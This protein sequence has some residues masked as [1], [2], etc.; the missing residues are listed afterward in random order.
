MGIVDLAGARRSAAPFL[1]LGRN[2]IAVFVL[3]TLGAI[4]LLAV[5][6]EG[7]DGKRR[8]LW[9]AIYRGAFE[10]LA[11]PR[12]SSLLFALAYLAVWTAFAGVLYR[13]RIFIKI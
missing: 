7:A 6:V 11:D 2:A 5:R 9:N 10:G 12:L 8:S 3:S 1:W 13:R 4:V